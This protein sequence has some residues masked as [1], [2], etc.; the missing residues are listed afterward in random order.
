MTCWL[1]LVCWF[2]RKII[3]SAELIDAVDIQIAGDKRHAPVTGVENDTLHNLIA[4]N[5]LKHQVFL[6]ILNPRA[7]VAKIDRPR[8][9]QRS[10]GRTLKI[11][12]AEVSVGGRIGQLAPIVSSVDLIRPGAARIVVVGNR[13]PVG[14]LHCFEGRSD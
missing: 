7:G 12:L 2:V 6:W 3:Q 14:R 11:G 9:G 13:K 4:R 5:V 10:T 1:R 8:V